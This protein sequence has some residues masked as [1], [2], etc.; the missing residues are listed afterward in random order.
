MT[1]ICQFSREKKTKR[2][3]DK[4]S[5]KSKFDDWCYWRDAKTLKVGGK[6]FDLSLP[7]EWMTNWKTV[8]KWWDLK[9]EQPKFCSPLATRPISVP[10]SYSNG[11]LV[12]YFFY[13]TRIF[14]LTLQ[15]FVHSYRKWHLRKIQYDFF[16]NFH[17]FRENNDL[18]GKGLL[19]DLNNN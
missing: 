10:N 19:N 2:R 14:H 15:D 16:L 3:H 11:N 6:H 8:A 7:M 18:A 5:S 17:F 1:G 9:F 12:M 13:P 4:S